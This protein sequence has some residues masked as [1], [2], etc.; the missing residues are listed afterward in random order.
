MVALCATLDSDS[1][2]ELS[3]DEHSIS[4]ASSH[5]SDSEGGEG[6]VKTKWNS[7]TTKNNERQ[8]LHSTHK[9]TVPLPTAYNVPSAQQYK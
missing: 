4:Y 2:S 6:K 5:S 7:D 3:A 8:L 9:G 1:D